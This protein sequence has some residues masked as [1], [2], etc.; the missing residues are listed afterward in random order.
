MERQFG[1]IKSNLDVRDY[2][3]RNFIPRQIL[4]QVIKEKKWEYPAEPLDQGTTTHCVG[5]SMA[6]WGINL[7]VHTPYNTKDAHTMY[8]QCK[9]LDGEPNKE[10]GSTIRSAAKVLR[11]LNRIDSFAFAP[12]LG[13]IKYW[14]LNRG[15][16]IVGT[17]WTESMMLPSPITNMLSINGDIVGGHAYVINEWRIDEYIGIQ[18][19]WGPDWGKNGKAYIAAA[20]FEKLFKYDGEAMAAVEL[21]AMNQPHKCV[22]GDFFSNLF[23]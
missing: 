14:L 20:D 17:V 8:Y 11:S 13:T 9:V 10:N 12:D 6:N 15:P 18:N 22:I 21:E 2:N 5:F 3:L 4:P 7:P 16:L 19:S 23:K 1:R